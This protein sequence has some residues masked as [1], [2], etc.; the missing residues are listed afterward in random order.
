[1]LKDKNMVSK[2]KCL[3]TC[4]IASKL[5]VIHLTFVSGSSIGGSNE[6]ICQYLDKK[7]Y[8]IYQAYVSAKINEALIHSST[9][10]YSRHISLNQLANGHFI[11]AINSAKL[12]I[13]RVSIYIMC[14]PSSLCTD[15]EN[16]A[17][18]RIY[19]VTVP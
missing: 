17:A 5:E 18:G 14:I 9:P 16:T 7:K 10:N 1:M 8:S 15:Q 13:L 12:N 19:F 3:I 2:L 11:F 4:A 6:Y